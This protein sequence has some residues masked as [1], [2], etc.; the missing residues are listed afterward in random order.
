MHHR[1]MLVAKR[2]REAIFDKIL[3]RK[4]SDVVVSRSVWSSSLTLR[5]HRSSIL[6]NIFPAALIQVLI[7][8]AC[9]PV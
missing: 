2:Q 4:H 7:I 6:D 3:H 9:D 8:N 5:D 1:C